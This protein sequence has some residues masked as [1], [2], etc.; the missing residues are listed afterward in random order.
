MN[1]SS[2]SPDFD[3][4]P[5][6]RAFFEI[7]VLLLVF[8]IG[9]AVLVP[10]TGSTQAL[11]YRVALAGVTA[12]VL[13][14]MARACAFQSKSILG[15][16]PA[17]VALFVFLLDPLT[18]LA[19][20]GALEGK[21]TAGERHWYDGFVQIG[22]PKY[23]RESDL[24]RGELQAALE[25][26]REQSD[27]RGQAGTLLQLGD[28]EVDERQRAAA[29]EAFAEALVIYGKLDDKGGEGR[30]MLSIG[31]LELQGGNVGNARDAYNRTM[32]LYRGV[33]DVAGEA[34]AARAL[35][36]V[37]WLAGN[38]AEAKELH[39]QALAGF[40]RLGDPLGK[41]K[42]LYGLAEVARVSGELDEARAY[43]VEALE[44]FRELE[45]PQGEGNALIVL[46]K[47]QSE[48]SPED[49]RKLF[50]GALSVFRN[51]ENRFGE[52]TVMF[53]LA[54]LDAELGNIDAA[55][56]RY[57][58]AMAMYREM[59]NDLARAQVLYAAARLERKAG[60]PQK[61]LYNLKEASRYYARAEGIE[62]G[63]GA[64]GSQEIDLATVS[65][66]TLERTP[67]PLA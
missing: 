40:E 67:W 45:N 37:E 62:E 6:R 8:V 55:R 5:P 53:A 20:Y 60:D 22:T 58:T 11:S 54:D 35:G 25:I 19:P 41:A 47:I 50:V 4:P 52:G 32:R 39:E 3:G 61:A 26:L 18:V 30:V 51:S 27:Y 28:L 64:E 42:A 59:D 56:G 23:L 1:G 7:A 43:C 17:T 33:M 46:G 44:L 48:E 66:A 16:L 63:E 2:V 9:L 14:E 38:D 29:A 31:R 21:R 49:A 57:N 65:P 36:G 34:R 13:S 24:R 15:V 12:L 10:A